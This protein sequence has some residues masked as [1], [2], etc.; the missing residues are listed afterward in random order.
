MSRVL[1][2]VSG[3]IDAMAGDLREYLSRGTLDSPDF[4]ELYKYQLLGRQFSESAIIEIGGDGKPRT[5][6][7][8]KLDNNSSTLQNRYKNDSKIG[9]T[10]Q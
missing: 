2:D 7:I 8:A 4:T 5:A 1:R 9:G 6:A 3:Q 10:E